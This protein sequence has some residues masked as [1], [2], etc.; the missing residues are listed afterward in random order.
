MNKA[1]FQP[2]VWS[3][4]WHARTSPVSSI[5]FFWA[6]GHGINIT[7]LSPRWR[8][9]DVEFMVPYSEEPVTSKVPSCALQSG[10][11]AA[12]HASPTDQ[13]S[14]FPVHAFRV[15][16]TS[17]DAVFF[18]HNSAWVLVSGSDFLPVI[19]CSFC[20]WFDTP[21]AC[22]FM[23]TL[24]LTWCTLPVI[25]CILC[26]WFD[27]LFY[28]DLMYSACDTLPVIW[29]TLCLCFDGLFACVLMY[30]LW[31]DALSVCYLIHSLP[32]IWCTLYTCD[33]MHSFYLWLDVLFFALPSWLIGCY[34]SSSELLQAAYLI[35]HASLLLKFI[36]VILT[37][38]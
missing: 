12:L 31:F 6:T 30:S 15:H 18:K 13:N 38:N 4:R 8:T 34:A 11:N 5:F 25:L 23:Y 1:W 24:P 27:A 35:R 22:D 29:C 21:F 17:F 37:S 3:I 32:V 28:C 19:W 16:S 20:L 33:L 14:A 7:E 26:L 10:Q 9:T 2:Y 36:S